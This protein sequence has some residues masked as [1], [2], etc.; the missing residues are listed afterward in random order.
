MVDSLHLQVTIDL[1]REKILEILDMRSWQAVTDEAS[2]QGISL[3]NYIYSSLSEDP[4]SALSLD[5]VDLICTRN[6]TP[7]GV[8]P[9]ISKVE[10]YKFVNKGCSGGWSSFSSH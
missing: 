4:D 1:S 3:S 6:H 8:G 9:K 7:F 10:L 5:I 2:K